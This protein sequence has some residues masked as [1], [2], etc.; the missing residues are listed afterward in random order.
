MATAAESSSSK[1]SLSDNC[2]S[3]SDLHLSLYKYCD[4]FLRLVESPGEL[5]VAC[6]IIMLYCCCYNMGLY[7]LDVGCWT[8]SLQRSLV[9]FLASPLSLFIDSMHWPRQLYRG[10]AFYFMHLHM[11]WCSVVRFYYYFLFKTGQYMPILMGCIMG[12]LLMDR[13]HP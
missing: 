6:L 2:S 4:R 7:G 8:S 10:N 1:L 11:L 5:A 12:A 3:M 9:W 13:Q